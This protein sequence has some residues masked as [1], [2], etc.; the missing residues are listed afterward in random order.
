ML[1]Q[2]SSQEVKLHIQ[3]C[4]AM[5]SQAYRNVDQELLPAIE[6]IVEVYITGG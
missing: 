4:L 3:E 2:E 5:M 6:N 1:S